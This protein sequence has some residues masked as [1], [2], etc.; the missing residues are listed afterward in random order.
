MSEFYK[1]LPLFKPTL[2]MSKLQQQWEDC[3]KNQP[4][5]IPEPPALEYT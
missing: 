4:D 2:K 3:K 5:L 1:D